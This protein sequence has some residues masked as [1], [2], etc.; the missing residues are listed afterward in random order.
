MAKQHFKHAAALRPD[1]CFPARLEEIAVLETA[2]RV[3]LK[4]PE[5]RII[6]VTFFTIATVTR[7]RFVSGNAAHRSMATS[8]PF[9]AISA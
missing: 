3:I 2:M 4:T 5:R 1:Y 6:S 8:Q 9:G 7:K